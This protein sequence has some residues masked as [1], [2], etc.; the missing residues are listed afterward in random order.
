MRVISPHVRII[1][2]KGRQFSSWTGISILRVPTLV[3]VTA[4]NTAILTPLD[5]A[6]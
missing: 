3:A 1:V 6:I 2:A 4:G 5:V